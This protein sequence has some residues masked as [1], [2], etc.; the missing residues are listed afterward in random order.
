GPSG[1]NYK[2][3]MANRFMTMAANQ[4]VQQLALS[5]R[6]QHGRVSGQAKQTANV[7]LQVS[8]LWL[9][10]QL[11]PDDIRSMPFLASAM[12][13]QIESKTTS[14]TEK[15]VARTAQALFLLIHKIAIG[16][17]GGGNH[18]FVN[19]PNRNDRDLIEFM[20]WE[21]KADQFGVRFTRE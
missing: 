3:R 16:S 14:D 2:R 17:L 15:E 20:L 4:A 13:E 12:T 6:E 18:Y 19:A 8:E 11:R 21:K 5:I 9:N 1:L 10:G 7:A